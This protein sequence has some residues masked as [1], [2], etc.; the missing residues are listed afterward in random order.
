MW[1]VHGRLYTAV[2]MVAQHGASKDGVVRRMASLTRRPAVE[3]SVTRLQPDVVENK[4]TVT[5]GSCDRH[6]TRNQ[7]PHA[8]YGTVFISHA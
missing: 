3:E 2:E 7:M 4:R 8:L 6:R 1:S 5:R